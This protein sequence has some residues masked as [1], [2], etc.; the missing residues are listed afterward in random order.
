VRMRRNRHSRGACGRS[1][2]RLNTLLGALRAPLHASAPAA[3]ASAG[4]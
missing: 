1:Q 3:A 2:A 4:A